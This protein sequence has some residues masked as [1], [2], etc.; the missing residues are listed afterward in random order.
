MPKSTH[1]YENCMILVF[2]MY[3]ISEYSSL[4][5]PAIFAKSYFHLHL[6]QHLMPCC[7][8]IAWKICHIWPAVPFSCV[9]L[10]D[11]PAREWSKEMYISYWTLCRMQVWSNDYQPELFWKRSY[12]GG[13]MYFSLN[14]VSEWSFRWLPFLFCL[15]FLIITRFSVLYGK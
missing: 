12:L 5:Y 8:Q 10:R 2:G 3:K 7:V 1:A 14:T 4:V 13:L 15:Q 6:G 9:R 11:H